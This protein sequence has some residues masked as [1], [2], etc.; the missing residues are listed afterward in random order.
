M[1]SFTTNKFGRFVVIHLSKGEKLL[2]SINAEIKRL[3]IRNGVVV[4]AIG[5]LRKVTYHRIATVED[6]PQDE[7]L[8]IEA[9]IELSA[10]QGL[11]LDGQPHLHVVF[12][13]LNNVYTG[14]LEEGCEVQYLAEISILEI[15]DLD[16]TRKLDEFGVSYI[17]YK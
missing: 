8:T 5:S 12:S 4:S 15:D 2:E 7:F 13:D 9:P 6:N 1:K 16:L 11:I 3:G 17:D 10:I 14:H